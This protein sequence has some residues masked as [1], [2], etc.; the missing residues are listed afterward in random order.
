[1][2]DIAKDTAVLEAVLFA[3]GNP[4]NENQLARV[5]DVNPQKLSELIERL[6]HELDRGKR[7][8]TLRQVA[9]GWQIVTRPEFYHVIEKLSEVSEKK[10]STPAMET[11]SIIAFKQ[12]I[13]KQEIEHIRGVRVER[14]LARLLELELV[15][16][17]G[18]KKVVGHPILYGT[19]ETFLKCFGLNGLEDLPR[20][21]TL[22]EAREGLDIEQLSL[23]EELEAP[24]EK[25]EE[26]PSEN[27][28]DGA[29]ESETETEE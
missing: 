26:E 10:L 20:L 16:E 25:A 1:M 7:G 28:T 17:K 15:C 29:S 21:P 27:G 19:T 8:L 13:T 22:E 11:L 14:S 18:R 23:I 3:A 12:P 24:A 9:G 5:L 2:S 6:Q 4:V